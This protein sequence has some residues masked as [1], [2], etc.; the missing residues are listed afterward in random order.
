MPE[1]QGAGQGPTVSAL[2]ATADLTERWLHVSAD[3]VES[4]FGALGPSAQAPAV[5]RT[6]RLGSLPPPRHPQQR[7]GPFSVESGTLASG[8][9]QTTMPGR[10]R[11]VAISRKIRRLS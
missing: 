3:G 7:W 6:K 10:Q 11:R 9:I 1:L 2:N 8:L 5:S 4:R